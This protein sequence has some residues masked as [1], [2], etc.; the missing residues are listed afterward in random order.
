MWR[1]GARERNN[2][3]RGRRLR[4]VLAASDGAATLSCVSLRHVAGVRRAGLPQRLSPALTP[5]QRRRGA[6]LI[7]DGSIRQRCAVAAAAACAGRG[8]AAYVS[9]SYVMS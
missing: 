6:A 9:S 8:E 5:G 7:Y 3:G 2:G 4:A 1:R